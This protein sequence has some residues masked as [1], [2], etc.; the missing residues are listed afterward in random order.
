MQVIRYL[1]EAGCPWDAR[2]CMEA[3]RSGFF[4]ALKYLHEHGCPWD[5]RCLQNVLPSWRSSEHVRCVRYA[6]D[7]GCPSSEEVQRQLDALEPPSLRYL[8]S[9]D[10]SDTSDS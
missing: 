3:I 9:D 7:H 6:V 10:V 2:C 8:F 4:S 5:E 1:H